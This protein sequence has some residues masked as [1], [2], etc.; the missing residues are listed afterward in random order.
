MENLYQ[1]FSNRTM[2]YKQLN[3]KSQNKIL[4]SFERKLIQ[5]HRKTLMNVKLYY[6]GE[7]NE[8]K[9]GL[10]II[11]IMKNIVVEMFTYY[12]YMNVY[13]ITKEGPILIILLDKD[14]YE[15][16]KIA[17]Q[18]E[19]KHI[20][21]KCVNIEVYDKE[22]NKISR[23]NFGQE[24]RK[25]AICGDDMCRCVLTKRHSEY[26]SLAF[27]RKKYNQFKKHLSK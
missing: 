13:R 26:E 15:V 12:I 24:T 8:S 5:T 25:C 17:M 19:E 4:D 27:M 3:L 7:N 6:V 11:D 22:C 16:K 14:P 10:K 2:D 1:K 21:G 23:T 9:L 20:L 18:I